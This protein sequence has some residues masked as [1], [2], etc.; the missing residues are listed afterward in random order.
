MKM[1]DRE[2]DLSR[3]IMETFK[4]KAKRA[5]AVDFWL[6]CQYGESCLFFVQMTYVKKFRLERDLKTID[7]GG[8]EALNEKMSSS[9]MFLTKERQ[10]VKIALS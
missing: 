7:V 8:K 4:W 9:G 2:K 1:I 10:D 5:M 3:P 6:P